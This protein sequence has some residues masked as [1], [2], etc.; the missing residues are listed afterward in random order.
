LK[1][2]GK[3]IKGLER[4]RNRADGRDARIGLEFEVFP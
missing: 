3:F 1:E 2:L 4:R